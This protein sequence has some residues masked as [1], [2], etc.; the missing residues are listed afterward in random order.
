MLYF[1]GK[2]GESSNKP[3]VEA[4]SDVSVHMYIGI[5]SESGKKGVSSFGDGHVVEE[6]GHCSFIF[7][8]LASGVENSKI[9]DACSQSY[10]ALPRPD[11]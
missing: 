3:I 8:P 2:G 4:S 1:E 5:C 10:S 7:V 11:R 6:R 9:P